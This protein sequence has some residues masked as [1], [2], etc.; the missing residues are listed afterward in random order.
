MRIVAIIQARMDSSRL[1]GKSVLPL[2][3]KPLIG[4]LLS[5]L[6]ACT[7]LDEIV[8]AVPNTTS[9]DILIEIAQ[10]INVSYFRGHPTNLMQRYLDC[11][12]TFN[13]ELIVRIPGDNPVPHAREVDRIIEHHLKLKRPGFSSN[14]TAFNNSGYPDGIGAEVFETH[15]LRQV[16][17]SNLSSSQREH[18]HL[19]FIDYSSGQATNP[20]I[21]PVATLECPS[22]FARPD[23][24]LDVN[25]REEFQYMSALYNE[26]S[27]TAHSF[28]M[29]D[30]IP[31]HDTVG[32]GL[33]I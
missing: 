25:T 29:H 19:N 18:I 21:A 11:A 32:K 31:W 33:K 26:F 7:K 23:I 6:K 22:S 13:A 30:I 24:V 4:R 8:L 15:L 2:A 16:S 27:A 20:G 10:S 14:L 3:G 5:R 12:D 9:N 28:D 17:E 1:P